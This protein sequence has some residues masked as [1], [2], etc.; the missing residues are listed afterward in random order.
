MIHFLMDE[1]ELV[2]DADEIEQGGDFVFARK[3]D[4]I[5]G[6]VRT[7]KC[8]AFWFDNS[9]FTTDMEWLPGKTFPE[10]RYCSECG[11]RC[12]NMPHYCPSCGRKARNSGVTYHV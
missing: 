1:R 6:G 11:L 10:G 9:S 2:L 7:E 8:V 12:D 4:R 5:V 3:N